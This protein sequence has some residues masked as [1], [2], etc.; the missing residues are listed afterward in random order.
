MTEATPEPDLAQ[1]SYIAADD[2]VQG[3]GSMS[4]AVAA[5]A[6][7]AEME[8][9]AGG[10]GGGA[11]GIGGGAGGIG[12]GAGGVTNRF[13]EDNETQVPIVKSDKERVGRNDPCWC[14]SGKKYK[15]C[16]GAN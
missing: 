15:F 1:A 14:G 3:S 16:H 5:G 8:E 7:P 13:A 9:S 11:G 4:A 6:T 10:I 2:P 12:G